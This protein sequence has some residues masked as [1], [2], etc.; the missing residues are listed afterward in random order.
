M[1]GYLHV[2]PTGQETI[3]RAKARGYS[4]RPFHGQE[5]AAAHQ[6]PMLTADY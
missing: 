3:S 5:A 4:V 2:V 1:P 6:P